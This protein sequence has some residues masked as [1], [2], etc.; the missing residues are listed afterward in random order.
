[1]QKVVAWR[2]LI[3]RSVALAAQFS[4]ARKRVFGGFG[5]HRAVRFSDSISDDAKLESH[6][7]YAASFSAAHFPCPVRQHTGA[8]AFIRVEPVSE[9]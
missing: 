7:R 8:R 6:A 9:L 4:I 1:M 3:K 2:L 5:F